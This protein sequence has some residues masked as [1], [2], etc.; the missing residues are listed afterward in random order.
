MILDVDNNTLIPIILVGNKC[1]LEKERV[2]KLKLKSKKN[3]YLIDLDKF[4]EGK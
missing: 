1:D 2:V 3:N 4:V